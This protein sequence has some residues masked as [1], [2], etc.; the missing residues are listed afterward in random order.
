M[1]MTST[2]KC[3]KTHRT[4]ALFGLPSPFYGDRSW[5]SSQF[6]GSGVLESFSEE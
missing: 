6:A 2:T 3:V 5:R 1:G 4:A